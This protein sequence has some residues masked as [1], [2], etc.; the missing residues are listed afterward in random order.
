MDWWAG[1][2]VPSRPKTTVSLD[3][4]VAHIV[5]TVAELTPKVLAVAANRSAFEDGAG[6][7]EAQ[8]HGDWV[9]S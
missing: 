4:T 7:L 2:S 8:S 9:R 3:F 6:M 5:P 1:T